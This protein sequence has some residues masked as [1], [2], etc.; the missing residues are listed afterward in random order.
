MRSLIVFLALTATSGA[1]LAHPGHGAHHHDGL[2]EVLVHTLG[3]SAPLLAMAAI[4]LAG[5]LILAR[6]SRR[7]R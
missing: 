6:R 4:V 5:W 7:A 2:A 3:W 1:A